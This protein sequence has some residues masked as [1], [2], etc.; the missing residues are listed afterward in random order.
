M[1]QPRLRGER[2]SDR[3]WQVHG[4]S[5]A[6]YAM[7]V[8][9]GVQ[10]NVFHREPPDHTAGV[11]RRRHIRLRSHCLGGAGSRTEHRRKDLR[12]YCDK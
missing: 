8:A 11:L 3:S 6:I 4:R 1:D 2:R 5:L 10:P 7:V 9:S 12:P